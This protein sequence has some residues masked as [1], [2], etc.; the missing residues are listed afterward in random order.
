MDEQLVDFDVFNSTILQKEG[1]IDL[2]IPESTFQFELQQLGGAL[3]SK[4]SLLEQYKLFSSTLAKIGCGHTQIYPNKNVLREWLAERKSLP[5]DYYL[6]GKKLFVSKTDPLDASDI[7]AG[8]SSYERKKKI[9]SNS[10]IISIDELSVEQMMVK[11]G[12]YISSDE[13]LIEFKYHQAAQLFEFYRHLAFP[14]DKDSIAV[15]YVDQSDTLLQY[16]QLGGAPVHTM[17]NRIYAASAIYREEDASIGKFKI[18]KSEY[19]Y[20]RFKSFVA[21]YGKEY[22]QFLHES[23]TKL[24][25]SKVKKLVIDLRGNTGGV[26]Q[27]NFMKY[28]LGSDVEL[29]RYVVEKPR[30]KKDSKFI[31]KRKV[32]YVKHKRMSKKQ[33]RLVRSG[34]F[35]NGI[36]K[37]GYVDTSLVFDGQI[38]VITDEGTFSSAAMLT[39]HLKSLANAKIVGRTP[40]GSFY[41]GNAGTLE[42]ELPK[43][44][45]TFYVN[46]NT[47]YSHLSVDGDPRKIKTP[48]VEL[49]PGFMSSKEFDAYYF[50][51]ATELFK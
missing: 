27:Y 28:I 14:L 7:N 50:K 31:K 2:H 13:G 49:N 3:Q 23:F 46:P 5:F 45:F 4:K 51:A 22:D 30:T 19:G 39:C 44:G 8:K 9:D 38:V 43:S 17:N 18:I 20:F 34:R 36:V 41:K 24:K 48:D 47:F 42:V 33:R 15:R 26:M 40:G 6:I 16:F 29:G 32:D 11:M 10:E 37:T 35:N 1:R 25:K 12:D 21:N